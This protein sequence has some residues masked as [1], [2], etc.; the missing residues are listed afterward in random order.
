[1]KI[2]QIREMCTGCTAC[3]TICPQKCIS[4]RYDDEGFLYPYINEAECIHCG[5][6]EK[7]CHCLNNDDKKSQEHYSYL[8]LSSDDE[9]LNTSSSSGVFYYLA[10][11]TL[12]CEG[13]VFGAAFDYQD[14][15]LKHTSTDETNLT[16]IQK[17]KYVESNLGDTINKIQASIDSGRNV[18]FCGTPCQVSG[19]KSVIKDPSEYLTT[20]DLVCHGVP[21]AILFKEHLLYLCKDKEITNIDFRPKE[22]PWERKFFRITSK[23]GE[24]FRPYDVDSFYFGF[25]ACNA[26][27]RQSCYHCHFRDHHVSDITLAD[28]WGWKKY[29]STLNPGKGLS[30]IVANTEK[31]KQTIERLNDISITP[32]DNKFSDYIYSEKDYSSGEELRN[33]FY[34]LY[35]E[36]GF[37][38]AARMT[39]FKE[40]KL[41]E[42]KYLLKKSL[43]REF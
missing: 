6:C 27:L 33:R 26:F 1:M 2:E 36:H 35:H 41:K 42:I 40:G 12:S 13:V 43:H 20:C 25:M 5:I 31:G 24:Y 8:G 23:E 21:S 10:Q 30:L 34:K 11:D 16:F 3:K 17:S 18:L 38:K 7:T 15:L 32:I 28:F 4:M 19:I 39:Y 22:V 14:R 37:E 29:D 9:V